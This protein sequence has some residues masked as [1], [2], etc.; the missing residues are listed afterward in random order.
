MGIVPGTWGPAS[1][2]SRACEHA[3]GGGE[4]ICDTTETPASLCTYGR[5]R[6]PVLL[7]SSLHAGRDGQL[8]RCRGACPTIEEH[9]WTSQGTLMTGNVVEQRVL[10][11]ITPWQ[12]ARWRDDDANSL[13]R[14]SHPRE[15]ESL[16]FRTTT[17]NVWQESQ[18]KTTFGS[19]DGPALAQRRSA[20][21]RECGRK[22][23]ETARVEKP[24]Q[25]SPRMSR[26]RGVRR[27][28]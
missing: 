12:K 23:W 21:E 20:R 6:R 22:H 14:V 2:L 7:F 10:L 28:F 15:S 17:V 19:G 24:V 13:H 16:V 18:S 5:R 1:F 3:R 27:S 25:K 9:R 4:A 26:A 8:C 11:Y